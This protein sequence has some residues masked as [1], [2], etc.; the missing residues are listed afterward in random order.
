MITT[1]YVIQGCNEPAA[2]YNKAL[3][4]DPKFAGDL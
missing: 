4:I 2:C 3:E 1:L